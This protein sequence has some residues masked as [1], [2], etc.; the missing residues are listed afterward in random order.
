[1]QYGGI[2]ALV[3]ALYQLI[4]RRHKLNN[5]F[6]VVYIA[7]IPMACAVIFEDMTYMVV[8]SVILSL[9][10]FWLVYCLLL[11]IIKVIDTF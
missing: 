7:M 2:A 3:M 10:I 1:M 6:K 8:F 11:K 4:F 5:E 9:S